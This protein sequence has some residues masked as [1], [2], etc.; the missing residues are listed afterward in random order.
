MVEV[1]STIYDYLHSLEQDVYHLRA[2]AD[3]FHRIGNSSLARELDFRANTIENATGGIR[4]YICDVSSQRVTDAMQS[5][6]NML[7]A[8]LAGIEIGQKS[9]KKVSK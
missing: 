8:A 6:A 4:E 9:E 2:L 1:K 5:S 3:A 7:N